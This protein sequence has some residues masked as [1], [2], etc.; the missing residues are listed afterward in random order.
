MTHD[1]VTVVAMMSITSAVVT[2]ENSHY[3]L[4]LRFRLRN[5]REAA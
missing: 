5:P 2:S 3:E 1:P 4:L